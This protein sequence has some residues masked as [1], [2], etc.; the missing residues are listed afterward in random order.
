MKN[1]TGKTEFWSSMYL[2]RVPCAGDKRRRYSF[3]VRL[4]GPYI[5]FTQINCNTDALICQTYLLH[6]CSE[7]CFFVFDGTAPQWTRA[8]S[9]TRFL[10]HTK[11]RTTFGRTPLDEWSAHRTDLYLITHTQ[12]S[13]QENLHNLGGIRTHNL[14]RRAAADPSLRP[15]GHWDRPAL[16]L[17]AY[18]LHGA[19][20]FLRS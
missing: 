9:F 6:Y 1:Y 10:D 15:R 8:S 14:S 3:F 4:L 20:Y 5:D 13:Q 17:H 7:V 19:E 12:Y 2:T 11:R 16:H 18:L